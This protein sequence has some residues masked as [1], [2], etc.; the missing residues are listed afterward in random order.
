M[1]QPC[2]RPL[3]KSSSWAENLG[4]GIGSLVSILGELMP[5]RQWGTLC[6]SFGLILKVST[7]DSLLE[8]ARGT[9]VYL[10][11]LGLLL[12]SAVFSRRR[13]S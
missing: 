8:I 6:L 4:Y 10:A 12:G 2:N 9:A 5:L 1:S 3:A 7:T 13:Q 11:L